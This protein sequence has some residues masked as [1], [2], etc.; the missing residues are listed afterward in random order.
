MKG[1]RPERAGSTY[2]LIARANERSSPEEVDKKE[3]LHLEHTPAPAAINKGEGEGRNGS[4]REANLLPA[5]RRVAE[6]D[7][8]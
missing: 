3:P 4:W 5:P 1:S 6:V 7:R 8:Q 2:S